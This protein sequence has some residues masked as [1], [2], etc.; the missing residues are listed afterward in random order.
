VRV[1]DQQDER[2]FGRQFREERDPCGVQ[3]VLGREWMQVADHVQPEGQP[4]DLALVQAA[5]HCVGRIAL[6]DAEVLLEDLAQRPVRDALAVRQAASRSAK[7][8]GLFVGKPFPELT[9]ESCLADAGLTEDRNEDRLRSFYGT[10]VRRFEQAELFVTSHERASKSTDATRAHERERAH[11]RAAR[12]A[13]GFALRFDRL[14]LAELE[15]AANG[16][17]GSL[18]GE[19]LSALGSLLE[20]RGDVDG[21]SADE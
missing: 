12:D 17:H 9:H 11:Q 6:E 7:W 8:L 20:A 19:D 16:G 1:L 5:T 21:V 18:T 3:P 15:C 13:A 2:T 14:R 10:V 4:E